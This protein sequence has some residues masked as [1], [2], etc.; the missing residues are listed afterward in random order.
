MRSRWWFGFDVAFALAAFVLALAIVETP[1]GGVVWRSLADVPVPDVFLAALG[2]SAMAARNVRTVPMLTAALVVAAISIAVG[3]LDVTGFTVPILYSIGRRVDGEWKNYGSVAAVL[4][5][6]VVGGVTR[7]EAVSDVWFGLVVVAVVWFV[8]RRLHSREERAAR[9]ESDRLAAIDRIVADEQARIARELH[10]VVAHRVSLMT[11]QAGAAKTVAHSNIGMAV[12][13]MEAVELAGRE[14][15]SELRQLLDVL[16][17][18]VDGERLEP[19]PGGGDLEA[20]AEGFRDAGIVVKT[21]IHLDVPTLAASAGLAVYRIVQES[22][23]NVLKHGGPGTTASV[24]IEESNES[25]NVT[26]VDDGRRPIG[27]VGSGHGIGRIIVENY[28]EP[29]APMIGM[30]TR[31]Q[32]FSFFL[33][34]LGL[35]FIVVA[36]MRPVY[37]LKLGRS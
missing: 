17:P 27:L 30:F 10:D 5:M 25:V 18:D 32:F 3:A 23:T 31:G 36:R 6:I 19:Q 15:L 37:P 1:D 22:L 9:A 20:L 21:D 24:T 2:A 4:G 28:R 34:A 16:R 26:I 14:A 33:V 11:V 12:Q 13:A 29:D 7:S 8:G 35:A